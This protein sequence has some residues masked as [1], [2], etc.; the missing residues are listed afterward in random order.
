MAGSN[1]DLGRSRGPGAQDRGWSNTGWVLGVR[2]IEKSGDVVCG[3]DLAQGDEECFLGLGSKSRSTVSR[4]V[5]QNRQL[6]FGD[7]CLKI[8]VTVS[9]FVSQNEASYGL[10]IAPQNQREEV[11]TEHTSKSSSLLH[12]EASRA[13]ISYF[14]SKLTETRRRMVC[15]TS[16]WRS[17]GDEVE[18]GR[19]DAMGCIRPLYPK[20]V[21][22]IVLATRDSLIF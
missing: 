12:V 22:F 13:M 16:S 15:M 5:P 10:S 9:C 3:L 19:V 17:H 2:T 7:L 8:T 18:D 1:E 6:Q 20:I 14:T 4:F 11:S 21:V